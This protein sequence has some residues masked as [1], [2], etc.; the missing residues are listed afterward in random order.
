MLPYMVRPTA[1]IN[2]SP[3]QN[4][5]LQ[6]IIR[7]REAP[8]SLV[9]RAQIVLAVGEGRTNK[10]IAEELG[11]CEETVGLWRKRWLQGCAGLENLEHKP[12]RLRGAVCELLADRPRSG[13]PGTFTAEQICRVLAL[14]CEKPPEHLSHWTHQEL[15]REATR[16][17]IVE[18]ISEASMG[19]FLKS[20]RSETPPDQVLA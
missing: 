9:Q 2:L 17:G 20:G 7:S 5:L 12:K 6:S 4:E 15:V 8:H 11:L 18:R 13:C 16:R 1:P 14:A 19:R 3:E 10:A